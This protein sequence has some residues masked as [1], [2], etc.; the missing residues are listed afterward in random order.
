[1]HEIQEWFSIISVTS[2]EVS[3]VA[4]HINA[5]R[6]TIMAGADS[7]SK[8]RGGGVISVIFGCQESLITSSLLQET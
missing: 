6:M 1:M 2:F 4:E 8:F 5:K 3:I 7:V